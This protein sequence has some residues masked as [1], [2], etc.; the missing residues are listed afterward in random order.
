MGQT[1]L[2][3]AAFA[4]HSACARLLLDSGAGVDLW[5]VGGRTALMAACECVALLLERGTNVE[6]A[7]SGRCAAPPRR[8]RSPPRRPQTRPTRPARGPPRARPARGPPR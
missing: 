7:D 8:P 4:G 5:G 2:M 6:L 3:E 1:A